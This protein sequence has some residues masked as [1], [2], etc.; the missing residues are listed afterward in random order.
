MRKCKPVNALI[1]YFRIFLS[2]ANISPNLFTHMA[3]LRL[4]V[5]FHDTNDNE[6]NHGKTT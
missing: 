3:I 6:N 1:K 4:L 2:I 5:F